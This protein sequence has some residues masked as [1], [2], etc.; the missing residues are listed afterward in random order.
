MVRARTS[1]S[2]CLLLLACL[3]PLAGCSGEGARAQSSRETGLTAHRGSFRQRLILS[4]ELEAERGEAM[5][6]PRTNA[7][8]LTIRW[9]APDGVPVKAGEPVV[10]FDNSQFSSDLEEKRLSAAQAGSDLA[11]AQAGV[12]TS[13][14]ERRFD[15]QKARSA[16]EKAK[17]DAAIPKDLLSLRE[18]Q[19]RQLAL[20][21][22]ET[23]LAKAEEVLRSES[24]V[25]DT[26]V[27]VKRISLDKSRREIHTAEESIDALAI[28]APRDGM[29]LL[30]SH[31]FEGR[32]FQVGDSV[33][34]GMAVATLP[35]LSSMMVQANLSDVDDG[36]VKPGMQVVC[37][38]DAYPDTT[39]RGR[40][41]DV[42]PVARESRRSQLLHYFPVRI[43]LDKVDTRRM[44]PGMSVRVEVLGDETKDVLLVPRAALDLSAGG[45]RVL[46]ASGGSAPVRLGPC[47]ADTCVVE[48]GVSAGTRLRSRDGR[49][50]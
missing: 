47:S 6:V 21:H 19:E 13:A 25:S 34:P 37:T 28:K 29:V 41:V 4:G 26:D 30:S 35:D 50:G 32:K 40:V 42:S 17:V 1:S 9:L 48:S 16:L 43:E 31:P 3:A 38:L 39:Y 10:A 36:R 20:K 49:A 12:K 18:Y 2:A 45:P 23:D 22:A 15:V 7:F 44:R 46:L 8:Q 27:E 14:S 33:W 11:T 24:K 5:N